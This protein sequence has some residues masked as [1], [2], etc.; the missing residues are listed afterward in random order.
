[1]RVIP[2]QALDIIRELYALGAIEIR[3][4]DLHVVFPP[5]PLD[6]PKERDPAPGRQLTEQ[7]QYVLSATASS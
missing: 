4:G 1:M 5:R 6:L 3:L 7:E 2:D